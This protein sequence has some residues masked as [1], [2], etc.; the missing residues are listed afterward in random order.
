MH[1]ETLCSCRPL[2]APL[3]C[4]L[5]VPFCLICP[6]TH[7][8]QAVERGKSHFCSRSQS[9]TAPPGS[10]I[11]QSSSCSSGRSSWLPGGLGKGPCPRGFQS[12]F[13]HTSSASWFWVTLLTH[14]GGDCDMPVRMLL[15]TWGLER[16]VVLDAWFPLKSFHALR[17]M[18]CVG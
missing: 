9:M 5:L 12:E 14:A 10:C 13:T 11:A 7:T 18:Y 8:E 2:T 1:P 16:Q 6:G 15:P 4:L 3:P 17:C